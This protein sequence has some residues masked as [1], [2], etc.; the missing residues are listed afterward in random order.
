MTTLNV[1]ASQLI[2]EWCVLDARYVNRSVMRAD[3][4]NLLEVF[5]SELLNKVRVERE[6]IHS[7]IF[8]PLEDEIQLVLFAGLKG[9]DAVYTVMEMGDRDYK[10]RGTLRRYFEERLGFVCYDISLE[11]ESEDEEDESEDENR[12]DA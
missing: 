3:I 11:D 10:I 7:D 2:N 12:K 6:D 1:F 4:L 8:A 9:C 5:E